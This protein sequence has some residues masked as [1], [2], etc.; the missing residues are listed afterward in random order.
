MPPYAETQVVAILR[1]ALANYHDG[2]LLSIATNMTSATTISIYYCCSYS[3]HRYSSP[4]CSFSLASSL[5]LLL[6]M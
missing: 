5:L 3:C 4:Y 2:H 1:V 6:L